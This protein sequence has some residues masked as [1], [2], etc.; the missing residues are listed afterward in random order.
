MEN[1]VICVDG[2]FPADFITFYREHGVTIPQEGKMYSF[3]EIIK[4][5]RGTIGVLLNEIHNPKV[6]DM[7]PILGSTMRE[8]DWKIQRFSNLDGSELTREQAIEMERQDKLLKP[9]NF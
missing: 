9:L 2:S 1:E 3:R 5:S 6:P 8:P 7:H 4:N